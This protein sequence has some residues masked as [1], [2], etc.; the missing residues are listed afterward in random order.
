MDKVYKVEKRTVESMCDKYVDIYF[1]CE[2]IE[3]THED[4][5]D[6]L[7]KDAG[8]QYWYGVLTGI[9]ECLESLGVSVDCNYINDR[10][11]V[12]RNEQE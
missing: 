4:D 5:W 1:V 2:R 11:E 8:Y 10:I 3:K 12:R 9:K 7:D 6:V